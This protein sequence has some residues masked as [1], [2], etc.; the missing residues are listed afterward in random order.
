MDQRRPLTLDKRYQGRNYFAEYLR[1][2]KTSLAKA[3][4]VNQDHRQ[5]LFEGKPREK[6]I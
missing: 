3:F 6:K 5:G 1:E 4:N 2:F